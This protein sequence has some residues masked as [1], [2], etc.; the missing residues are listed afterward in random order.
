MRVIFISVLLLLNTV[1]YIALIYGSITGAISVEFAFAPSTFGNDN[2]YSSDYSTSSSYNDEAYSSTEET[3]STEE[4]RTDDIS[5]T[6]EETQDGQ[7]NLE[8]PSVIKINNKTSENLSFKTNNDTLTIDWGKIIG[9]NKDEIAT[10]ISPTHDGGY[11]VVGTTQSIG[12]EGENVENQQKR[13]IL[14]VKLGGDGQIEWT[15]VLGK[16]GDNYAGCVIQT[17]DG[18]YLVVGSALYS[19]PEDYDAYVIK[20]DQ[21]GEVEWENF[22]GYGGKDRAEFVQEVEDNGYIICGYTQN[23]DRGDFDFLVFKISENGNNEWSK[24]FGSTKDDI[25][26]CVKSTFDG[27]YIFTGYTSKDG[28]PDGYVAYL[29]STGNILWQKQI[30]GTKEDYFQS[31]EQ[32]YDG[33]Y[34]A[35]GYTN[36]KGSKKYDA[37]VVKLDSNGSIEWEKTFGGEGNDVLISVKKLDQNLLCVG[38]FH[39]EKTNDKDG[40][41]LKIDQNGDKIYS[42]TIDYGGSE[43]FNCVNVDSQ[44][45]YIFAG[46]TV[47]KDSGQKDFLILKAHDEAGI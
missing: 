29:S 23:T 41:I 27:N 20:L 45:N 37:Y 47:Y 34:V 30:G 43:S 40:Y 24:A 16:E 21:Y 28:D 14:V 44:W 3:V 2:S 18:G 33:G 36:S 42:Y 5:T 38:Y 46:R 31:I 22:Y 9:E 39:S 10:Y 17:S 8:S 1:L 19:E 6:T 15:R 25:G 12:L 7:E 11:I 4:V 26:M 13:N 35:V 32:T